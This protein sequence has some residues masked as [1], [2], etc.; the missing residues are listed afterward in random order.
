MAG[1]AMNRLSL[2]FEPQAFSAM[3]LQSRCVAGR[4]N[5]VAI[6]AV[7]L[8]GIGVVM[9]TWWLPHQQKDL[10]QKQAQLARIEHLNKSGVAKVAAA[11]SQNELRASQFYAALG[12]DGYAEQQ[13][14]AMFDIAG[15]DGLKL[16]QGEYKATY[17]RNSDTV[18]YQIELPVTGP[19]PTIRQFCEEVLLAIPFAALDEIS[20]K[21]ETI[22]SAN[23]EAKLKFTLYLSA[24]K[25]VALVQP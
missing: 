14:K 8:F 25:N 15:K 4:M 10:V 18:A 7:V 16:N 21:R 19:Y 20:F 3:L 24:A 2:K 6:V 1:Q 23:L 12:Q 17:A 22:S 9:L 5:P 11:P 13:L